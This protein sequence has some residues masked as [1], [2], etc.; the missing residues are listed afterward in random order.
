MCPR[1]PE[2]KDEPDRSSSEMLQHG[3]RIH[4]LRDRLPTKSANLIKIE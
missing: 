2:K 1:A 4:D 3:D